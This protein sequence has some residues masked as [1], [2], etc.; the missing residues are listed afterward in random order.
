MEIP[1]I[2]IEEIKRLKDNNQP[3][4]FLDSRN[5]QAWAGSDEKIP[6]AIRV[7]A[8][9]VIQHLKEIPKGRTIITYC[10]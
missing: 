2:S 7:P 8:D 3:M 5:P 10:T 6:G 9:Q 1:R 4:V